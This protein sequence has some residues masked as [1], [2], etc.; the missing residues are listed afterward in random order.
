MGGGRREEEEW[1]K[2]NE[3]RG[4]KIIRKISSAKATT[5]ETA[6]RATQT[7]TTACNGGFTLA[8]TY[9]LYLLDFE[10]RVFGPFVGD[11]VIRTGGVSLL[12]PT[13]EVD[14]Q[15]LLTH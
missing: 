14:D 12:P 4:K 13:R 1:R 7:T 9:D 2:R 6:G 5:T 15:P 8:R 11:D 10:I 3:E